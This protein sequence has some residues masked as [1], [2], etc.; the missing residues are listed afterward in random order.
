MHSTVSLVSW[1]PANKK[2]NG[3]FI[4]S[5][6]YAQ[7]IKTVFVVSFCSSSWN[8]SVSL[9]WHFYAIEMKCKVFYCLWHNHKELEAS[10]HFI[11]QFFLFRSG[12]I[13]IHCDLFRLKIQ[14]NCHK[15]LSL[16]LIST[17]TLASMHM[18]DTN[19]SQNQW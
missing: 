5:Q 19:W 7:L 6:L 9:Q 11:V 1:Y 13:H 10:F 2:N 8:A 14:T 4:L 16:S 12:D 18:N 15:F 17:L 3:F